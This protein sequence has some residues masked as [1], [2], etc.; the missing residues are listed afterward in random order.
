MYPARYIASNVGYSRVMDFVM[1][2]FAYGQC[3]AFLSYH[4]NFPELFSFEVLHFVYMV[5]FELCIR[6]AAQLAGVR[7]QPFFKGCPRTRVPCCVVNYYIAEFVG[8]LALGILRESA[9]LLLPFCGLVR[10]APAA[11]YDVKF[12]YH[13]SAGAVV[14]ARKGF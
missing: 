5:H 11:I 6:F 2:A 4:H 1:T 8:V 14:L 12:I 3:L 7:I 9:M 13:F 10:D